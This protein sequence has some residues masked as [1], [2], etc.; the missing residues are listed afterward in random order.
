[1]NKEVAC[2]I[3]TGNYAHYAMTLYD[4]LIEFYPELQFY[5]FVSSGEIDPALE[6][7][8]QSNKNY[9]LLYI[10]Q[11]L[12]NTIAKEL[13]DKYELAYHD[14]YRWGMK[15]VLLNHLLQLGYERAIYL[16]SDLFFY[17]DFKFLFDDLKKHQLLLSPH[18]RSSNPKTDKSN[19]ELN[20]LDGI[21]NGGFVGASK[22]GEAALTY[23]AELCL[24]NCEANRGR[25]YY[26]DQKYLDILPTRF[27]G[28]GHILHKGCNVAN[29]NQI[30]CKRIKTNTEEVLING[31]DPIIFIHFTNSMFRGV[32]QQKDV[33][34][35]PYL[36]T[37]KNALLKYSQTDVIE[38]F[39][40]KGQYKT[41]R[42]DAGANLKREPKSLFYKII[43][44]LK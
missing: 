36:D 19:F 18:W 34:L 13:H 25:G 35:K 2:T 14:A 5:V 32:L 3:I 29:W 30:D 20:F 37:Y 22:G 28:V 38:D 1:M 10:D 9:E 27:E 4:S 44:K 24:Y 43:N 42:P 12:S 17:N 7:K 11:F 41:S 8:I 40:K 33:L 23:W 39:Y 26:V 16:D 15:P 31:Q 6:E 21:Y